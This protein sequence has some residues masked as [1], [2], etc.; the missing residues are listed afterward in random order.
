MEDEQ[1]KPSLLDRLTGQTAKLTAFLVALA[2]L[3]AA[4]PPI[5]EGIKTAYCGIRACNSDNSIASNPLASDDEVIP[6]TNFKSRPAVQSVPALVKQQ[7][8]TRTEAQDDWNNSPTDQRMIFFECDY[9]NLFMKRENGWDRANPYK[10]ISN[11]TM[12]SAIFMVKGPAL[13]LS[14]SIAPSSK[15]YPPIAQSKRFVTWPVSRWPDGSKADCSSKPGFSGYRIDI[16]LDAPLSAGD[17]SLYTSVNNSRTVSVQTI[18]V[19]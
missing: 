14:L 15:L 18:K 12:F 9:T 17:Y 2:A 11:V 4:I 16:K 6:G 10:A 13:D 19:Q 3:V 5:T 7:P 8:K 1:D